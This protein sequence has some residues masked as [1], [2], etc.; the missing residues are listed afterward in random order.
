MLSFAPSACDGVVGNQ[1][2]RVP[3]QCAA[4]VARAPPTALRR[5]HQGP[6]LTNAPSQG[7]PRTD[8]RTGEARCRCLL[9]IV[10]RLRRASLTASGPYTTPPVAP[11]LLCH[12]KVCVESAAQNRQGRRRVPESTAR[13]RQR[14]TVSPPHMSSKPGATHQ[15]GGSRQVR[16]R[17]DV[18]H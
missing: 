15:K 1:V 11:V 16:L 18:A 14:S 8:W 5:V 7:E 6:N 12:E 13:R 10:G 3:G 2:T 9:T 4:L 17:F